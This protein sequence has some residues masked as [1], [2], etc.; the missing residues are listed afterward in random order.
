MEMVTIGSTS[1]RECPG[2]DG[3]W[4]DRN[5]FERICAEKEQQRGVLGH[6]SQVSPSTPQAA[7]QI[8][9]IPCP[10]CRKLMNRVNFANCSGVIVD[11]CREHG[12]WFDR[13]ELRRIIE[14]IR[15]GGLEISREK[16]RAELI[17]QEQRL[18]RLQAASLAER[19]RERRGEAVLA[20]GGL[21]GN[22]F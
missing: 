12:T 5:S 21:L 1:V 7:H 3:L 18:R 2:C 20:A 19:E 8:R 13:D 15:A 22:Y 4:V 17:Q 9:Y 10:E 11:V 6:P 14:F 16:K